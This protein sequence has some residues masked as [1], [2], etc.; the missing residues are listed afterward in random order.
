[1]HVRVHL[2]VS[3]LTVKAILR[4]VHIEHEVIVVQLS[5]SW[6]VQIIQDVLRTMTITDAILVH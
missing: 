2:D 6:S 4:E 1:M 5:I 3:E